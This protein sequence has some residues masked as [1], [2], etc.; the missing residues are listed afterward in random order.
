MRGWGGAL[1]ALLALAA[2]SQEKRVLDADQPASDP[3]GAQD[4]RT[5]R[6]QDNAWQVSEGGRYFAW[7]GCGTCHGEGAKGPLNLADGIWR[8]GSTPDRVYASIA[9]HGALGARILPEQRWQLAAYV[10]QLPTLDPAYR[11][12][13]DLD[14]VGEAQ[15][16]TW[17]GPVR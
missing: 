3:A 10:Q 1:A 5:H 13:Q 15:A 2:C 12:R 8:H 16:D 9:G 4:P 7:Y 14:Q 6:F 17:P 11:R